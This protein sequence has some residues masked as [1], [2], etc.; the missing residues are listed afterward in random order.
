ML[1]ENTEVH[2]KNGEL[3]NIDEL[4]NDLESKL[5]T[6]DP[7]DPEYEKIIGNIMRLEQLKSYRQNAKLDA[8]EKKRHLKTHKQKIDPN[9]ALQVGGFLLGTMMCIHAEMT[10]NITT[11]A[12]GL[13]PR[14]IGLRR[15]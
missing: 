11:K 14:M 9:V 8:K 12:F 10:G 5:K 1:K 4:V 3:R 13:I 2:S 6:I 15:A 7:T